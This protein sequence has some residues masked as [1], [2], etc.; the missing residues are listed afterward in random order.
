MLKD[1]LNAAAQPKLSQL[2]ASSLQLGTSLR[3][4]ISGYDL[5]N[6]TIPEGA[7][8]VRMRRLF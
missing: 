3:L 6:L 5:L 7:S 4:A 1:Q 2:F 8:C